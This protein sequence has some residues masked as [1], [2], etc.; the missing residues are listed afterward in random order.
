M[1]LAELLANG[2]GIARIRS[3]RYFPGL[4]EPRLSSEK[5]M[6]AVIQ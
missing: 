5:A 6:T 4:L 3:V 1:A 2:P